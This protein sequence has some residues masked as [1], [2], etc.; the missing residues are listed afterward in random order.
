MM[1]AAVQ[2][3]LPRDK[4]RKMLLSVYD[5]IGTLIVS[6][7]ILSLLLTY[8]FRV[9]A[10]DGNSMLPTL[11]DGDRLLL[12]TSDAE[13]QYG[14]IV[15]VD[16]YT[17][18]PLIK[19][20]IAC[21]GQTVSIDENGAVWVDGR[22]IVEPY[23]IGTTEQKDFAEERQIPEGYLFVMGDNREDSL[24]SRSAEIDLISEKDVVGRVLYRIWP[25][26]S[27]GKVK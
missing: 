14:D 8:I 2:Q 12:S 16:R 3:D 6:L 9:V 13:Y 10:V 4:N 5:W 17:R 7:I 23:I 15:V 20:V 18:D 21:G 11:Q 19:R 25:V 27:I 1:N 26:R 22:V 24:D